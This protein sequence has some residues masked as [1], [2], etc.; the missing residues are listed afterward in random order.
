MN[1]AIFV[2]TVQIYKLALGNLT[3]NLHSNVF[4]NTVL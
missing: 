4:R 2:K 3:A 1:F